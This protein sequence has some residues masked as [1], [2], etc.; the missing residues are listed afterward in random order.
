MPSWYMENGT[1]IFTWDDMSLSDLAGFLEMYLAIPV[2]DQTGISAH[3]D[4]RLKLDMD[5]LPP[6][7]KDHQLSDFQPA[8]VEQLGLKLIPARQSVKM[9]VVEKAR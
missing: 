7:W 8:L 5:Q 4:I 1:S 2:I 9:L 3:F 6:D